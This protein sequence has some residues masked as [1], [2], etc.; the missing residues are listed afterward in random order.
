MWD[1]EILSTGYGEITDRCCAGIIEKPGRA[2]EYRAA[3]DPS[4]GEAYAI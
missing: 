3:H 1:F 2:V 4:G